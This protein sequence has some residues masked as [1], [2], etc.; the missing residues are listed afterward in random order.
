[1]TDRQHKE[2]AE[3]LNAAEGL[4]AVSNYECDLM[5][6]LYPL[7]KW[8]KTVSAE[9]TI[10]STKDKRREAIWTNYDPMQINKVQTALLLDKGTSY[11][12]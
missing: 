7:P 6:A 11:D 1:M 2:L 9:R 3:R 4:V 5:E 8:I 10:H 12:A